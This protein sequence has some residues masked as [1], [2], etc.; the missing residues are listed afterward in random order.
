L[1]NV[2]TQFD[3]IQTSS[4]GV[5]YVISRKTRKEVTET[6]L[7]GRRGGTL[8]RMQEVPFSNLGPE[9]R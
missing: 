6:E 2:A 4:L 8:A 5:L 1:I 9:I 7:Y 3:E